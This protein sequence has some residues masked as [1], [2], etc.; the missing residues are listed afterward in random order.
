MDAEYLEDVFLSCGLEV[1]ARG[2]GK[3]LIVVLEHTNKPIELV[4]S[5]LVGLCRIRSKIRLLFVE[6]LLGPGLFA[7][8]LS[9]CCLKYPGFSFRRHLDL[10]S[11]FPTTDYFPGFT[12][13]FANNFLAS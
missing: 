1:L 11:P 13:F 5:P 7:H 4:D 2:V 10:L 6:Q 3:A 8:G 9:E 12:R